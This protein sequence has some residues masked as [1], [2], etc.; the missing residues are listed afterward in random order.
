MKEG[1]GEG[2]KIVITKDIF[3]NLKACKGRAIG[4]IICLIIAGAQESF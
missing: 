2:E 4:V 1:E 3:K